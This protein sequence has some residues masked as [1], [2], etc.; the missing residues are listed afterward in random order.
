MMKIFFLI[1]CYVSNKII[2]I[3]YFPCRNRFLTVLVTKI[4]FN[5]LKIEE[6]NYGY[7]LIELSILFKNKFYY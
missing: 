5:L 6:R 4:K 7:I 1:S 3:L 2:A